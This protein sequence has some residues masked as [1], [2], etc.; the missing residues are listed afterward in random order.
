MDEH[1]GRR[2][3]SPGWEIRVAEGGDLSVRPA[4]GGPALM[5]DTLVDPRVVVSADDTFLIYAREGDLGETDLWRVDLPAGKPTPITTWTGSEDRPVL[6]PDGRRLA[7]VSGRT[8]IASW[9]VVDLAGP[10]A[11]TQITN[12]GVIRGRP[13]QAPAG[14]VPVPDGTTYAWTSQ[15]LTWVAEGKAYTAAVPE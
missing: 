5:L 3:V 15:G 11:G 7:F 4:N 9:W 14:W 8:G 13:G 2:T 10:D 12:V 1:P 6:S